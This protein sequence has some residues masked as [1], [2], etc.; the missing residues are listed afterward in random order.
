MLAP[1]QQTDLLEGLRNSGMPMEEYVE[2]VQKLMDEEVTATAKAAGD[3]TW[4]AY[5]RLSD[6]SFFSSSDRIFN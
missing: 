6:V 5:Y 2:N 3:L 1:H 4:D